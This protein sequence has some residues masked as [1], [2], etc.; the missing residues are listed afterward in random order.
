MGA[1]IGALIFGDATDRFGRKRFFYI[2]LM[3][4]PGARA[5]YSG[6]APICFR[7]S[8][9]AAHPPRGKVEAPENGSAAPLASTC[10]RAEGTEPSGRSESG[11][12]DTIGCR[13]RIA[14][15]KIGSGV[16]LVIAIGSYLRGRRFRTGSRSLLYWR[17]I[18]APLASRE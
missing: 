17:C 9:M 16:L 12:F 10:P 5:G 6:D 7:K 1:V 11:L 4:Y 2:T 8:P 14:G 18:A 15:T 3:F 13:K